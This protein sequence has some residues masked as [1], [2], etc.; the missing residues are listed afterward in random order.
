MI[1]KESTPADLTA[2]WAGFV[3]VVVVVVGLT[4]QGRV[5]V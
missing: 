4:G 1:K 2:N 3:V 5:N